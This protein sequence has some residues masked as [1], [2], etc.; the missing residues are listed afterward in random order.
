MP[1]ATDAGAAA[2]SSFIPTFDDVG[3]RFPRRVAEEYQK[4]DEH[5]A[6][7][8][9][10]RPPDF[11][12]VVLNRAGHVRE[13]VQGEDFAGQHGADKSAEAPQDEGNESLAGAA[14]SFVRF[15]VHVKLAGNEEEI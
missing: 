11:A 15:V 1:V 14:D 3:R 9:S 6:R 5:S 7:A 2:G 10:G 12:P 8:E 13:R 4:Q